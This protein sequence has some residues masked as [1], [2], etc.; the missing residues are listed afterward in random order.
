MVN[1][2][3]V[4][5]CRSEA[6]RSTKRFHRF[7]KDLNICR[8][9]L[10]VMKHRLSSTEIL[11]RESV[12]HLRV[13]SDHFCPEDYRERSLNNALNSAAV[14]SVFSCAPGA[15]SRGTAEEALTEKPGT[16]TQLS[17]YSEVEVKP[18]RKAVKSL[19]T[20]QGTSV[21]KSNEVLVNTQCLLE[22]FQYC[23]LCQIECCITI[24]GHE[25]LF[26][27]T[28]E[29]QS[30]GFHKQWRSHP[31]PAGEAV[32]AF[33]IENK[34][35]EE[36]IQ[37]DHEDE[38]APTYPEKEQSSEPG[39]EDE[40]EVMIQIV[41]SD[42]EGTDQNCDQVFIK[43]DGSYLPKKDEKTRELEEA[44]KK[45]S[46]NRK[47]R[48]ESWDSVDEGAAD[49][50][51]PRDE[52][53]F[54]LEEVEKTDS[55]ER[56]NR[57]QDQMD[58]DVAADAEVSAE[59][60]ADVSTDVSK[61]EGVF[62]MKEVGTR[63]MGKVGP[64]RLKEAKSMD[65]GVAVAAVS[66]RSKDD[67]DC[68]GLITV[69]DKEPEKRNTRMRKAKNQGSFYELAV[70]SDFSMDEDL[71]GVDEEEKKDTGKRGKSKRQDSS[72]EWEPR[73]D[74]M[75]AD[76]DISMDE[77]L[78][79]YLIEDSKG[80]V[81]VWCEV[82]R[83]DAMLSCSVSRHK[84]VYACAQCGAG[85]H[86]EM[87]NFENLVVHFNDFTSFQ[88]H[89]EKKHE[90]KPFHKPCQE[91]GKFI[92]AEPTSMGRKDHKCEKIKH[93]VCPECGKRFLTE[94]GLKRHFSKLHK[95]ADHPC[96]YCL[97]LFKNRPS[98]LE[99]EQTHPKEK[100]PYSCPDC[101]ERFDNIH[102]RNS[103]LKL[104][105]GP[106]KYA[107]DT[108]GKRFRDIIM[109]KRHKLI[110]SGEKPFRCHVCD[111]SFNQIGNLS[112]HMRLHTGEKPFMCEQCGECFNHNV[113]LKNHLLRYHYSGSPQTETG[114]WQGHPHGSA[115]SGGGY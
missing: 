55:G 69:V 67:D 54:I 108:C 80:K 77:D 47:R 115:L 27:V 14:P 39:G 81:V 5:G 92:L 107:C 38:D 42:N 57:R 111:R 34:Q 20:N 41:S 96:K 76:A 102:K 112:S 6:K 109:L 86:I 84:K 16:P 74:D 44:Q 40:D 12:K 98:K 50:D 79:S 94:I 32:G 103:H 24:E 110:H 71:F 49:S 106:Y 30:C 85:D 93:I 1:H 25:R 89:A 82:C 59:V 90:A 37:E 64:R 19:Q 9:W 91:C 100:E 13:C 3:C 28:Q 36:I 68:D 99:H 66:D 105:R 35:Q 18:W 53:V 104:H 43:K 63:D 95:D 101:P 33:K 72:D 8:L 51:V 113:S 61:D 7:P 4:P 26:S 22:L 11:N 17:V 88:K 58:V 56:E 97:K 114:K 70:D 83:T 62:I 87:R 21:F 75:A 52:G 78:F 73:L 46:G 45:S 60:S 10:I 48:S 23:W 29:C 65:E 15:P 31:T 2:C